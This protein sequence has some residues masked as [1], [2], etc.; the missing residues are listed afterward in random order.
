MKCVE[1]EYGAAPEL[2]SNDLEKYVH[3]LLNPETDTSKKDEVA[4][5]AA[6]G[7]VDYEN[8]DDH[9]ERDQE[10]SRQVGMG[11]LRAAPPKTKIEKVAW[12]IIALKTF[13]NVFRNLEHIPAEAKVALLNRILDFHLH[14]NM[15]LIDLFSSGMDDDH[16]TS[17]CA[18][19]VTIGGESF[20]SQN[21][22][23]AALQRTIEDLLKTTKNDLKLFLLLCIYA[24]LRLP[25]YAGRLESFLS[26]CERVS[27]LE[28]GY[29]KVYELLVRYEG[30][31]LPASL[32]SVFNTAFDQRQRY[33]GR[34][35]P[36]DHQRLR[37]K[38]LNEA[39]RRFLEARKDQVTE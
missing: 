26:E 35:A 3:H 13:Y 10:N 34:M 6:N 39:K 4:Q 11:I 18:Y 25:G 8:A 15:D 32:I 7:Q 30:Q 20:L 36:I 21:V 1:T 29:A 2:T 37:D 24:D 33:Y 28:M 22:G 12:N 17:L 31:T 14:C 38:E 16:F 9:F 19:M 23:S 27:I 5:H